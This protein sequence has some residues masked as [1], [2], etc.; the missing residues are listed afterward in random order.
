MNILKNYTEG[1]E[2]GQMMVYMAGRRTGKSYY[3]WAASM[4]INDLKFLQ[5]AEAVV[6]GDQWYSLLVSND[7]ARWLRTQDKF[8]A[9]EGHAPSLF[10]ATA[11]DVHETVYSTLVLKWT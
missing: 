5:V 6:D 3:S 4:H 2:P 1:I 9:S 8:L 7:V 11:F 10:G